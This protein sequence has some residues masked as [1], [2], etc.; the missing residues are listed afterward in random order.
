LTEGFPEIP[1]FMVGLTSAAALTYVT[2]K[3][4]ERESPQIIQVAPLR[5]FRGQ[6]IEV[7]GRYLVAPPAHP[8]DV[9]I[10]RNNVPEEDIAVIDRRPS[11]WDTERIAVTLPED[12]KVGTDKEL[13]V[14]PVGATATA[15]TR[16]EIVD[17]TINSVDPAPIPMRVDTTITINGS[18]FGIK[19]GE[20]VLDKQALG[21][22]DWKEDRITASLSTVPPGLDIRPGKKFRLT[23]KRKVDKKDRSAEF[24]VEL[25]LPEMK[26]ASVEPEPIL[27][28]EGEKVTVR[29]G[30]FGSA[31]IQSC[32][33][34][35]DKLTLEKVSWSDDRVIG[36][37]TLDGAHVPPDH[38]LPD[39]VRVVLTNDQG[40]TAEKVVPA[41]GIRL[42]DV[43]PQ[44]LTLQP[45]A[46][47]RITGSGFGANMTGQAALTLGNNE[48]EVQSWSDTLIGARIGQ[49]TDG[50]VQGDQSLRVTNPLGYS[51]EIK[52][53][54]ESPDAP[55]N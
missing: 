26:I 21:V 13:V 38:Q 3:A 32:K 45:D 24:F 53:R 35:L 55:E 7:H 6:R 43:E 1:A 47:L 9:L 19:E 29:G 48:L 28:K 16:I 50:E 34:E 4:V 2:K 10:D 52:V 37:I 18:G 33:I 49:L 36:E 54:T 40:T 17:V 44:P 12:L 42:E 31:D 23:V 25:S 27:V 11:P 46:L 20:V 51:N 41:Q 39:K 30:G 8:P 5:A 14:V 22:E 15:T